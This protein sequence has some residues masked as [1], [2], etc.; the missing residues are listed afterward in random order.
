M[1]KTEELKP[2]LPKSLQKIQVCSSKRNSSLKQKLEKRSVVPISLVDHIPPFR[3]RF[4]AQIIILLSDKPLLIK[5]P[6]KKSCA[7]SEPAGMQHSTL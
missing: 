2:S 7:K 3:K 4:V 1:H 5:T 6:H